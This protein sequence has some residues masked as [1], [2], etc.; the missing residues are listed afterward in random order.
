MA[1][2]WAARLAQTARLAGAR[3]RDQ[4]VDIHSLQ[5]GEA[6][7]LV[8]REASH[9]DSG[10]GVRVLFEQVRLLRQM[11]G[12]QGLVGDK[13]EAGG[14]FFE[15]LDGFPE[16]LGDEGA[17]AEALDDVEGHVEL[18]ADLGA[19]LGGCV[20]DG[21]EEDGERGDEEPVEDGLVCAVD[22][23]RL[24]ERGE[25]AD[26]FLGGFDDALG[27]ATV[28]HDTGGGVEDG[29]IRHDADVVT[30][31]VEEDPEAVDGAARG[32]AVGGLVVLK[33]FRNGGNPLIDLGVYV[34][35][36]FSSGSLIGVVP[37]GDR[38]ENFGGDAA[39]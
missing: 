17:G 27:V 16:A 14:D 23:G 24:V 18:V 20:R 13:A 28:L 39:E 1:V 36:N 22:V 10:V 9:G 26:N 7:D 2:H 25:D 32:F 31:K 30:A 21:E 6:L 29:P 34:I 3:V 8:A 11:R 33:V 5:A 37:I 19:E 35:K 4:P 38:A 12:E 15:A